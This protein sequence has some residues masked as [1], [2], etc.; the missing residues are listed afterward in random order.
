MHGR[1]IYNSFRKRL[2]PT[3]AG[4]SEG[5]KAGR[6][7]SVNQKFEERL[8]P[9][10]VGVHCAWIG[11]RAVSFAGRGSGRAASKGGPGC[12]VG[13]SKPAVLLGMPA[14][15]S[16][17]VRPERLHSA[18]WN[19]HPMKRYS[20]E[21]RGHQNRRYGSTKPFDCEILRKYD[22]NSRW[23]ESSASTPRHKD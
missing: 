12:G 3:L 9:T 7:L 2:A 20:Q 18:V 10:P 17:A 6:E 22:W 1:D 23:C 16:K 4:A 8:P 14:S 21:Q 13:L 5:D 15:I 11:H 19:N